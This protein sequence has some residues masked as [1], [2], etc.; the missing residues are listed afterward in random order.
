MLL[1]LSSPVSPLVVGWQSQRRFSV[2]CANRTRCR[3]GAR[4]CYGRRVRQ[5]VTVS[6]VVASLS[7]D[8][9][10]GVS[11]PLV[12]NERT[13]VRAKERGRVHGPGCVCSVVWHEERE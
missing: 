13:K 7:G 12:T 5:R 9:P 6:C 10:F 2:P 4:Q 1:P 3:G 11:F 8:G